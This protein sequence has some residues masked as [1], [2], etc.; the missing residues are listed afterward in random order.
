MVCPK[1]QSN[2]VSVQAVSLTKTKKRGI[3]WWL[4]LPFFWIV[5]LLPRK[6]KSKVQSEAVCQSCG[7]RWK[8]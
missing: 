2:N 4:M 1:C 8:V 7:Y 6:V 3:L 5:L